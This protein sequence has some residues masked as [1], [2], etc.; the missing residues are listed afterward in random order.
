MMK[1]KSGQTR[2]ILALSGGKDSAALA[3]YLREKVPNI[4]YVFMD[5][6]HELPETYEYL[7]RIRA[8][9]G[10]EIQALKSKR[11]FDFYLGIYN[12]C[13]PCP[14]NRWCTKQLKIIPYEK[15]IGSDH[16]I[17]YIA[18]RADEHRMGYISH[19]PNIIP[20]YPFIEDDIVKADVVEILEESGLGLPAY[21][22]W[23]SR[24]GCYFCFFQRKHEWVGLFDRHPELFEK[25]IEYESDHSDGRI[26]TWIEGETLEQLLAR[27]DTIP[28]DDLVKPRVP[29]KKLCDRLQSLRF[30]VGQRSVLKGT[31][32]AVDPEEHEPCLICTL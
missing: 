8:V 25:A 12:G 13:L 2:H 17:S 20:T 22:A 16:A 18:L 21:Y 9:L 15:Y 11:D 5:T 7:D 10:I 32:L 27:R 1:K 19:K 28:T 3:V 29:S 23:R 14:Q 30:T 24:S 26:Y 6:G 31:N 4:E